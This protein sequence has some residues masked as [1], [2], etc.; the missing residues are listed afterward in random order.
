MI[1]NRTEIIDAM[2]EMCTESG[3]ASQE[4]LSADDGE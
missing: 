4:R 2:K 3:L 1:N